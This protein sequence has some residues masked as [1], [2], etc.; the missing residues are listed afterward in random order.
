M[1]Q[2]QWIRF[3]T[4]DVPRVASPTVL[5]HLLDLRPHAVSEFTEHITLVIMLPHIFV[6]CSIRPT[7][8]DHLLQQ[9]VLVFQVIYGVDDIS[10]LDVLAFAVIGRE[11]YGV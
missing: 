4:V 8:H 9:P 2:L 10:E 11:V 7:T 6:D 5:Q 3:F 1:L